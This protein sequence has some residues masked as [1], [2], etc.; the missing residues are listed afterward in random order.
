VA[1]HRPPDPRNKLENARATQIDVSGK[2]ETSVFTNNAK[3]TTDTPFERA[4]TSTLT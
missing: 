3:K 4:E 1:I 2:A